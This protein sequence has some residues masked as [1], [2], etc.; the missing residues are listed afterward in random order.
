MKYSLRNH[1][2]VN[3]PEMVITY[4]CPLIFNLNTDKETECT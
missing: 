1:L 3:G 2:D 4:F